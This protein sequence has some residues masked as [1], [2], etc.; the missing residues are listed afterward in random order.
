MKPYQHIVAL[1]THK[2]TAGRLV[3]SYGVTPILTQPFKNLQEKIDTIRDL[4]IKNKWAKKGDRIV[5]VSDMPFGTKTHTSAM[6]V[7][8]L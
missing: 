7:E 3:M 4:F 1:T 5:I 6:V 2:K 8:T